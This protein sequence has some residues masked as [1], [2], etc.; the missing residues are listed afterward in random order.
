MG[1]TLLLPRRGGTV[2]VVFSVRLCQ[3][4][5][6]GG[7]LPVLHHIDLITGYI[8]GPVAN[9]DAFTNKSA[10]VLW[11]LRPDDGERRGDVVSFRRRFRDVRRSFYVRLRGTNTA[12]VAPVLDPPGI[13]PWTDLWFYS[14]P[15]MVRV[16]GA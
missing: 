13:D 7:C 12:V 10:R 8:D 5:N 3:R 11:Q 4:R 14:N 9:R 6:A 16:P 1:G 15:L 2:E